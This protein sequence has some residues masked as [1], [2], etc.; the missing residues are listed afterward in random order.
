[1][2][3][4][5]TVSYNLRSQNFTKDNTVNSLKKTHL[6]ITFNSL[7]AKQ[8]Y[9][10]KKVTRCTGISIINN[11]NFLSQTETIHLLLIT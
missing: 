4:S 11:Y 6:T 7:T 2:H 1:M 5:I 8:I 3:R 9:N 10:I